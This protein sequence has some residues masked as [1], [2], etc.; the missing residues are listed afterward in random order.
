MELESLQALSL[1]IAQERSIEAIL[2]RVM[3]GL[4]AQPGV[5]LARLW[6]RGPGDIC[7]KCPQRLIC[8]DQTECLH[9]MASA[10]KPSKGLIEDWSRLDGD[11]RRFPL[12]ALK[13]G[14]IGAT[15]ESLL[16]ADVTQ[17]SDWIARPKWAKS[18]G[19]RSFAGQPLIFRQEVLGVLAI[20]S[21]QTLAPHEFNW[22]RMFAD[23]AAVAIANSRAF[24]E[25]ERLRKRLKMENDY[26]REE[27]RQERFFG[28]IIGQSPAVRKV[29]DQITLVAPTEANVLILGESGTGKEMIAR[30]I[31]ERSRRAAKPL[32]KVNCASIPRDLFESEFFGHVRGAF[33]GAVRD[34]VG[35][36]QL[37]EEG[38]LFLD[39]IG[40]I[41][42]ELQ[43]KLLRVLQEGTFERVGEERT[44]RVNVRI[45]AAT[46]R[47]LQ[48]E[49]EAGNFRQDLFF[50]LSV[51]PM[52]VP[53]LR[54]RK[55]D[56]PLLVRH[57]IDQAQR[58]DHCGGF[59]IDDRQ[60]AR[61]Q[62]YDWPGNVRE[63]QNVI[64][65]LMILSRCGKQLVNM[66]L[67]LPDAD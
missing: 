32:V 8:P 23:H 47:D 6:L 5:A 31:H 41:P 61:L 33:T 60:M 30:A 24:A 37:A 67:I 7:T 59:Q 48:R 36:F 15:G 12:G 26:L 21:R 17:E 58:R 65:R 44:R 43:S 2:Q 46:N 27:V 19:I 57:F 62:R 29:V 34:R 55:E 40:E 52:E 53:P 14:K 9:L 28:D 54:D 1:A 20:F 4:T 45:V 51:F 16:L 39:E 18:E 25:I 38:T 13:V 66:D 11:F 64:E 10:G 42:L 35:R 50:R 22:L 63:L 56:I 3:A 49:I